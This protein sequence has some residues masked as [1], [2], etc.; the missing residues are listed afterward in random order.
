MVKVEIAE[1]V[2]ADFDLGLLGFDDAML[3]GLTGVETEGLTLPKLID[4]RFGVRE[5]ADERVDNPV[6]FG[7]W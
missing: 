6:L 4:H 1:L 2:C 5:P 7:R 3:A